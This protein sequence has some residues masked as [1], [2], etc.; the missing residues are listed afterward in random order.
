M[1]HGI[2][3][4]IHTPDAERLRAFF[5]DVVGLPFVDAG[6]GWLIFALPPAELG[7][8]PSEGRTHHELYLMCEDVEAT[9]KELGDKG[10]EFT[11]PITDQGFGL[12]TSIKLPGGGELGL[13]QPKHPTALHLE[14]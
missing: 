1:I 14:R 3:T 10:V 2:H 8:H 9:M 4:L 11:S 5:R 13:Y 7:I 12:M 6:E